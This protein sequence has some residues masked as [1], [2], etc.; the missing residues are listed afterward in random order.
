MG[1]RVLKDCGTN[2]CGA[3]AT[4]AAYKLYEALVKMDA[5]VEDLLKLCLYAAYKDLTELNKVLSYRL[6][7]HHNVDG[8]LGGRSVSWVDG[9]CRQYLSRVHSVSWVDGLCHI[10]EG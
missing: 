9:L 3:A 7:C 2:T 1:E 4:A 6:C 10:T 5:G 8:K